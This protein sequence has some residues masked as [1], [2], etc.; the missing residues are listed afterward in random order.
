MRKKKIKNTVSKKRKGW[1][2]RYTLAKLKRSLAHEIGRFLL[3]AIGATIGGFATA[4]FFVPNHI[5]PGGL[6]SIGIVLNHAF[7]I[8]VGLA[9][10]GMNIPFF[11]WALFLLGYRYLLRT[12]FAVTVFILV[13]DLTPVILAPYLSAFPEFDLILVSVFGGA[14]SGFGIG[15]VYKFGG[16]LGGTDIISQ[17]VSFTTKVSYGTAVL[18]FDALMIVTLTSYFVFA[19]GSADLTK[20]ELALYSGIAL[21]VTSRVIDTVQAGMTA[22]RMVIIITNQIEPI[23]RAILHRIDRGVTIVEGLGGYSLE[24]RN[25]VFCA[26]PRSQVGRIKE[27]VLLIDQTAFIMVSNLSET[28]GKGFEKQL[29]K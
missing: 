1:F 12:V 4:F 21:F 18:I 9:Y 17:L 16:S 22:T 15:L 2:N 29:P 8:K 3:I 28:K 13:V 23:R 10:I 5:A 19:G 26:I 27:I 24:K 14:L 7:G 6:N 25:M 20:I 11:T